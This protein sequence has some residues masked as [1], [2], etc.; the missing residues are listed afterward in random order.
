M[1][2]EKMDVIVVG[3][4]IVGTSVAYHLS[5][6][7]LK[8]CLM[9]REA[10]GSGAS[11]HGHGLLSVVGRDFKPGPYFLLGLESARM[12]PDFVDRVMDE[13]NVAPLFQECLGVNLALTEEEEEIYAKVSREV[14][15]ED[16]KEGSWAKAL[17]QSDGD[18]SKAKI[19]YMKLR[20]ERLTNELI[21]AKEKELEAKE[22]ENFEISVKAVK[23]LFSDAIKIDPSLAN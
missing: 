8:V 21:E 12:F 4:G 10:V 15:S 17:I 16:R 6:E 22:K 14:G 5:L 3:A 11:A 9:D 1:M 18:E 19:A 2:D 20:V 13:V 23:D 7:G